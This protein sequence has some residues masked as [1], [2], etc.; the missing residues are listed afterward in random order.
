MRRGNSSS[1]GGWIAGIGSRI[2]IESY[3]PRKVSKRDLAEYYVR[4]RIGCCLSQ[5][6][7]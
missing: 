5:I 7:R 2:P 3:M 1:G 6:D 4:S